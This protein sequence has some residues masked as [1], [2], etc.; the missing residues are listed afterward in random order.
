[1]SLALRSLFIA[2]FLLLTHLLSSSLA[3]TYDP[4]ASTNASYNSFYFPPS[5]NP[6]AAFTGYGINHLALIVH[7]ITR[8]LDFYTRAAGLSHLFTYTPAGAEFVKIVYMGHNNNNTAIDGPFA[9]CEEFTAQKNSIKGLLELLYLENSTYT[10]RASTNLTNT[11]SHIGLIVPNITE[12]QRRMKDLKVKILKPLGVL[13][14]L[15]GPVA[16][17][18]GFGK[19]STGNLC[20]EEKEA[21]I[22]G[23]IPSGTLEH[24][25]VSDPDGNVIEIQE[26]NPQAKVT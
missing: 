25:F 21:I 15:E 9:S 18:Y 5:C 17:A 4:T 6:R 13:P 11:F 1:M 10:P 24:L 22:Q 7:D 20:D 12:T 8:S 2:S 14:G 3:C 23:L 16:N 19:L 26:W